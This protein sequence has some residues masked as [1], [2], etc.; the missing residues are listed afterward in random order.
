[1]RRIRFYKSGTTPRLKRGVTAGGMLFFILFLFSCRGKLTTPE[2]ETGP[3][4]LVFSQS[5][6]YTH[7]TLPTN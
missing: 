7:L 3:A 6:S 2:F 5:V 4:D 1:M